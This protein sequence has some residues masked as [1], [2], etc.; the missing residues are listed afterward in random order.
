MTRKQIEALE[1]LR[2]LIDECWLSAQL[3]DA[4][5]AFITGRGL[6]QKMTEAKEYL[7]ELRIVQVD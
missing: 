2:E 3:S 4:L 7:N 5:G 1:A 6:L